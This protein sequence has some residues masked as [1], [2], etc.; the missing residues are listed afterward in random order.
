[1]ANPVL[2]PQGVSS[3]TSIYQTVTDADLIASNVDVGVKGILDDRVFYLAKND[4]G[5]TLNQA[6]LYM[7]EAQVSNHDNL[8]VASGGAANTKTVTVTLGG[9]LVT[10][11]QYRNGFLLVKDGTGEGQ[12]FRIRSH[13]GQ[14]T[15][16]GDVEIT[17]YD[18]IV[19]G[20]STSD[21][22]CSLKKNKWHDPRQAP[23]NSQ[24]GVLVGV[25]IVDIADGEYGWMQ[26]WG[27]C[28]IRFSGTG[29]PGDGGILV[30]A[31]SATG[32][33]GRV[34]AGSESTGSG[35]AND[36]SDLVPIVGYVLTDRSDTGTGTSPDHVLA[37]LRISP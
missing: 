6:E 4:S 10:E 14:S 29:T 19:T 33:A 9:T 25:P 2:W 28:P 21:S 20:L 8:A 17:L 18:E 1:M 31:S 13:P 12:Y 16:N 26:T 32:E 34:I 5:S 35:T 30:P 36:P 7:A 15:T 37:D 23:G 27:P 3:F 22:T 11:N 24:A